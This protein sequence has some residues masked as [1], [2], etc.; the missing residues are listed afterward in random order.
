MTSGFYTITYSR[1]P[2]FL[3]T[4]QKI[5]NPP[6]PA[7]TA[8]PIIIPAICLS[9]NPFFVARTFSYTAVR[10]LSPVTVKV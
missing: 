7:A 6:S 8:E 2:F 5:A 1:K 3:I 4:N 10:L 9:D